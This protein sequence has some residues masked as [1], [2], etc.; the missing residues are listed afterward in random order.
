MADIVKLYRRSDKGI[1]YHEAWDRDHVVFEHRGIVG[2][3]GSTKAHVAAGRD[4]DA[5]IDEILRP[6]RNSGFA[7]VDDDD[8]AT[9]LIE[10]T[11]VGFDSDADLEKRYRLQERMNE[12][13]GWRGLGHCDGG[14]SG[15][16]TM[17]VC[18]YVIDFEI[19]KRV[20]E[21]DLLGT[22]FSDF[23]RIYRED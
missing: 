17:E 23:T 12:T 4:I 14:S 19:A 18:C 21:A 8:H 10:F 16:D 22:E 3:E 9:L 20:I 11:V 7:T 15:S 5:F 6:A 13:L 2:D 1:E